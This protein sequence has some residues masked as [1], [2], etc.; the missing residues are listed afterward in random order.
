M[1]DEGLINRRMGQ[2]VDGRSAVR[3]AD[4]VRGGR[5]EGSTG[6]TARQ[7]FISRG[8]L[9]LSR[10]YAAPSTQ[11]SGILVAGPSTI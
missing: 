11:H 5:G 10:N 8:L 6:I 7:T 2:I 4:A 9:C 3:R 1:L